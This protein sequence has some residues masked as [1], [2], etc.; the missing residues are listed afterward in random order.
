[1]VLGCTT[2]T[3]SVRLHRARARL[4]A[5]M[6]ES[7]GR[8]LRAKNMPRKSRRHHDREKYQNEALRSLLDNTNTVEVELASAR[9]DAIWSTVL[10]RSTNRSKHRR[11]WQLVGSS[12]FAVALAG[13]LIGGLLPATTSLSVAATLLNKAATLDAPSAN[14][15][16]LGPG[17]YYYESSIEMFCSFNGTDKTL[18]D[19]IPP[20]FSR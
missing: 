17:D 9:E 7:R 6:T 1:M 2:G 12:A 4:V 19:L 5:T 18:R 16:T 8:R 10:E 15:P 13:G 14:L 20:V 11:R 3:L